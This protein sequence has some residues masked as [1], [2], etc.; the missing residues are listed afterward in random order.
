MATPG[1]VGDRSIGPPCWSRATARSR[2]STTRPAPWPSCWTRAGIPADDIHRFS[3]APDILSQPHVQVATRARVLD[4]I[5]TCT[6]R[7]DRPAWCSSPRTARMARASTSRRGPSSCRRQD[8]DTALHAGCGAAPTVAIVSAC[9]TGD[10]ARPPLAQPNRILL[11]AAAADRPSFGCG[12]GRELTYYDQCLLGSLAACRATGATWSP[13]P[14]AAS[15]GWRRRS[16]SRPPTRRIPS[17]AP[18]PGCRSWEA[19][20]GYWAASGTAWRK[21]RSCSTQNLA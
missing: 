17:A 18:P 10:F 7:P 8:L 21:L 19:D 6:R 2:C 1:P 15:R 16:T 14:T 11:T 20:T 12:A 9:Y 3:A 5:A 13:R 4:A